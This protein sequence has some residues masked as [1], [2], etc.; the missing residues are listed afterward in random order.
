MPSPGRRRRT[1]DADGWNASAAAA[2]QR[3]MNVAAC[4]F[5]LSYAHKTA[6]QTSGQPLEFVYT[7]ASACELNSKF[8]KENV[9]P[10]VPTVR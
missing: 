2:K 3:A 8:F 6:G 10:V 4:M 7:Q 5:L 1:P 9:L